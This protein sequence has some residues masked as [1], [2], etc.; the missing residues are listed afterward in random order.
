MVSEEAAK[1]NMVV[2]DGYDMIPHRT[3]YLDDEL[4]HPNDIGY[5]LYAQNLIK[6]LNRYL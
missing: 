2:I 3:E 5:A 4:V 1:R 6:A